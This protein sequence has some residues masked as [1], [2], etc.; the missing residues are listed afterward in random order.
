M[1]VGVSSMVMA[2]TISAL[3]GFSYE[4]TRRQL[5]TSRN[6][7]LQ[8]LSPPPSTEENSSV[9]QSSVSVHQTYNESLPSAVSDEDQRPVRE[10]RKHGDH[11][12]SYQYVAMDSYAN[13][14]SEH[15][16]PPS[17]PATSRLSVFGFLSMM[18][19][20]TVTVANVLNAINNNNNNNDNNGNNNNNNDLSAN[21]GGEDGG[22]GDDR[23]QPKLDI[24]PVTINQIEQQNANVDVDDGEVPILT[25][26]RPLTS[27]PNTV[28]FV[29]KDIK[30][31]GNQTPCQDAHSSNTR[32][33]RHNS[34]YAE[35]SLQKTLSPTHGHS[36]TG[37]ERQVRSLPHIQRTC[38]CHQ[39]PASPEEKD[40]LA[41]GMQ[42]GEP[43]MLENS[44]G[45]ALIREFPSVLQE[46]E[47]NGWR[48]RTCVLRLLCELN[49][50]ARYTRG[51]DRVFTRLSGL[52]G[53]VLTRRLLVSHATFILPTTLSCSSF[54]CQPFTAVQM[55]QDVT[56]LA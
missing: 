9:F 39:R 20:I 49:L 53:Q 45:D 14:I 15:Y 47:G 10:A 44:H 54:P 21:G 42:T 12:S 19:S 38:S 27:K 6:L 16:C 8:H 31:G 30:F 28:S 23:V 36:Y 41:V 4:T 22:A 43:F 46:R 55:L 7:L 24:V 5:S 18:V 25:L 17:P 32:K 26:A 50:F 13:T 56:E 29:G 40:E 37:Q 2:W 52:V 48:W 3:V 33:W 1:V 34:R 51:T 11:T 35:I